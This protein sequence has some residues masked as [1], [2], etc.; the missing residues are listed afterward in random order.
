MVTCQ[1]GNA[2]AD[3]HLT[4][5]A[6]PLSSFFRPE[7][8]C[9]GVETRDVLESLQNS[10]LFPFCLFGFFLFLFRLTCVR[11][12][13]HT[14]SVIIC[15]TPCTPSFVP[16]AFDFAFRWAGPQMKKKPRVSSVRLLVLGAFESINEWI[17]GNVRS[18]QHFHAD[19]TTGTTTT[20]P[21]T[22]SAAS[23]LMRL[24]FILLNFD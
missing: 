22:C 5:R 19:V 12:L 10:T 13:D 20:P 17:V 9:P 18:C 2:V 1:T 11:R 4:G 15:Q 8:F 24:N 16:V 14:R 7:R 6:R 21:R 23:R 3:T